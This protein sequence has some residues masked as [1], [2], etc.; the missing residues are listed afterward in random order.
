[1]DFILKGY[2]VNDAT[3]FYLSLL[4][5]MAVFFRFNRLWSLRNLDIVLLLC[6]SPGLLG[7]SEPQ[8]LGSIWLFACTGLFLIRLLQC[9]WHLNNR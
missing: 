6:V 2:A 3:W 9:P 1:M 7:Q 4:L 5:I 8:S